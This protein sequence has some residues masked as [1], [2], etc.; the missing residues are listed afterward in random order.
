MDVFAFLQVTNIFTENVFFMLNHFLIRKELGTLAVARF[1]HL[2]T[3]LFVHLFIQL[4]ISL[5]ILLGPRILA[6]YT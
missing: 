4:H 6:Y 5:T 2:F 1:V 3:C